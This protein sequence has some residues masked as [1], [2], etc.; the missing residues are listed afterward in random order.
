M[1]EGRKVLRC[2]L[3]IFLSMI[4]ISSWVFAEDHEA[5]TLP[6]PL[7]YVSDYAEI[8]DPEWKSR[9]RSVCK[10]LEDRT[11]VEMIVV[12][13]PTV[14]PK[15]SALEYATA[16]YKGW[17]IGTAQQERG[18]L[19]LTAVKERQAVVVLGRSLLSDISKEQLIELTQRH[20]I[21]I[22][23]QLSNNLRNEIAKL[24]A[25][26]FWREHPLVPYPFPLFS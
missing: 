14:Y 26:I 10:E 17:R 9:I 16:L 7:G 20:F 25:L 13:T 5:F 19:M 24:G 18:M 8:L 22:F 2:T 23:K 21:P 6:T 11:G 1:C 12:T 15:A 3:F 4:G